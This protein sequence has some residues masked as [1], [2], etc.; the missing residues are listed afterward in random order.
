LADRPRGRTRSLVALGL[1]GERPRAEGA[2]VVLGE[3]LDALL[4]VLEVAGTASRQANALLE[5]LQRLLERQ[6]A[7]LEPAHDLLEPRQTVLKFEVGHPAPSSRSRARRGFRAA[8]AREWRHRR[9]P[10]PGC[11][12]C[13][14]PACASG[15]SRG[16]APPAATANRGGRRRSAARSVRDHAAG[17]AA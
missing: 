7:R 16:R 12:R 14:P 13:R 10:A 4:G 8:A 3:H 9:A 1:P 6:I 15:Y 11:A 2:A 17:G 5:D